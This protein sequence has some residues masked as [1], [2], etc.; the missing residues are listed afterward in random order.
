MLLWKNLKR[1]VPIIESFSI[2]ERRVVT[3][4]IGEIETGKHLCQT[5]YVAI[6]VESVPVVPLGGEGA[7]GGGGGGG[8]GRD[9][10]T[11]ATGSVVPAS[12]PP[13]KQATSI[14]AE[15]V[16]Q[17]LKTEQFGFPY[18]MHDL[19]EQL[20]AMTFRASVLFHR[21]TRRLDLDGLHALQ[22]EC[23]VKTRIGH[24]GK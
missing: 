15:A 24:S 17:N 1:N 19:R 3:L 20:D 22:T 18:D 23:L 4:G 5:S 13:P 9:G 21:V 7:G 6:G 16:R 8:G 12:P 11:T 14:A 10:G 2:I